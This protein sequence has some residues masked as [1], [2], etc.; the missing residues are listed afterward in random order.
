[1]SDGLTTLED[2][3]GAALARRDGPTPDE[4][5]RL[6]SDVR[7][8]P[9][10]DGVDNDAAELLARRFEERLGVTMTLGSMLKQ[11]DFTPW[12]DAAREEIEPYYWKRYSQHLALSRFPPEVVSTLDRATD[13]V[14]GLL[15]NPSKAGPWDRRGMVVGY[16]QSGKTAHYTGLTCKA[17]DAGYKLIV[18]VA[19]L[20]NNLRN[21]TQERIDE[22]FVGRDST[23]LHV[24]PRQRR[25]GVGED[26]WDAPTRDVY[27]SSGGFQQE[28]RETACALRSM[29]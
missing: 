29:T 21:Q 19:G 26:R 18:V 12:L 23:R 22:G 28:F 8:L 17:A 6:I 4:I 2:M 20:H 7:R 10:C 9:Q 5:R 14:L 15:E 1:M 3:V 27:D 16:V 25:V 24:D 13:R 11:Q